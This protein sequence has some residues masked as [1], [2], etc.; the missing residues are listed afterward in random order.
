MS[1]NVHMLMR[2]A[3]VTKR[4]T[5]SLYSH[6]HVQLNTG[7]ARTDQCDAFNSILLGQ[8]NLTGQART[9]HTRG[10]VKKARGSK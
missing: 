8:M 5:S 7:A 3:G 6:H 4:G 1:M 10:S 9:A 2:A